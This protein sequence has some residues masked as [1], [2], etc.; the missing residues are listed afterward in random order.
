[1]PNFPVPPGRLLT[2]VTLKKPGSLVVDLDHKP[3][4]VPCLVVDSSEG[5][6]RVRGGFNLKRGQLVELMLNGDYPTP[7]RCSVVWV[8]KPGSK[9]EG[10]AGVEIV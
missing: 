2:R 8:G 3:K 9:Q 4:R 6:F 5:G 1:M 7:E 10:E